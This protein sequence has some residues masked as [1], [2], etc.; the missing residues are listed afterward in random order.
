MFLAINKNLLRLTLIFTLSFFTLIFFKTKAHAYLEWN[1]PYYDVEVTIN[2]DTTYDVSEK[3]NIVFTG[4]L[5]GIRRDITLDDPVKDE[6]CIVNTALT[7]GGFEFLISK[8]FTL[9]GEKLDLDDYDTYEITDEVSGKRSFR[10]EK[11]LYDSETYVTNEG[12]EWQVD[13]KVFGGIQP[14]KN[15]KGET[16]KY[17]YWNILPEDRGGVVAES[18]III[19]LPEDVKFEESKLEVYGDFTYYL[20]KLSSSSFELTTTNLP[21]YSAYT[22]A[23]AF[24]EDDL[25]DT[26]TLTFNP[27]KP[28]N[29]YKRIIDNQEIPSNFSNEFKFFPAGKHA[30]EL[31]RIGYQT[32]DIEVDLEPGK[33]K[34]IDID[35][36]PE[37]W[38][39][40]LLLL[41]NLQL[42]LG[43][44]LIPYALYKGVKTYKNRGVDKEKQKTIIPIFS[45]PN[46]M[47]PYLMGSLVDEK[48]DLK[49]ITSTL[50]DLA[51]RGFIKIKEINK[52]EF[53]LIR[54]E[55]AD[56]SELNKFEKDLLD[57]IFDGEQ[58]RKTKDMPITFATKLRDLKNQMYSEL[59]S[60]GYFEKSPES[61]RNKYYGFGIG[62]I[63]LGIGT[64]IFFTMAIVLITG[65]Y[66]F[67]STGLAILSLGLIYL[68]FAKHMP[69]KTKEGSKAS[70]D[71]LGFKMYLG[72]AEK[73]RL[74][75]LKPEDFERYLSYAIM[76]GVEKQWAE[77]FKGIYK[78]KPEWYEGGDVL[79]AW[80]LS[81]MTNSFNTSV[82]SGITKVVSSAGKGSG[83]SGSGGGS[84]GGFSGGG[85]GGGSSGGW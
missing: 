62:L 79:D 2:K 19:N 34:E 41:S 45:P 57:G 21:N 24:N 31:R 47:K 27:I 51:Y 54:K 32:Q 25:L 63:I 40:G 81:N 64:T 71:A 20:K 56:E 39:S 48:A 29:G 85:G 46:K 9:N 70:V 14:L 4:D 49:D 30:I 8:G 5:N 28:I 36:E 77:S 23:Y 3:V 26:S 42:G 13:Y 59:V 67:F 7:C 78:L 35:L 1:Y 12:Y 16:Q 69:A 33:T 11:R 75:N 65:A 53:E 83:W 55:G 10:Y 60:E 43:L 80:V 82:Q 22:V 58:T 6:N 38:M 44:A 52:K 66:N 61:T 15:S 76:F 50:I 74:Q 37:F 17:F 73:Y 72:T 18:K 84:F 68:I